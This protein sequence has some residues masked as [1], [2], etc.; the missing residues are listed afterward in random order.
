MQSLKFSPPDELTAAAAASAALM[1]KA[2]LCRDG[3]LLVAALLLEAPKAEPLLE[4]NSSTLGR[5]L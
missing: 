2:L 3:E 5:T 1:L 4:K